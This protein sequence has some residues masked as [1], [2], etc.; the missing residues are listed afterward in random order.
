VSS[1]LPRP[2]ILEQ[3]RNGGG[4]MP[5]FRHLPPEQLAAVVD[6]VMEG[7]DEPGPPQ[8]DTSGSNAQP[9]SSAAGMVDTAFGDAYLFGGYTKFLDPDRYPAV[10]PPWGT[11]S[12]IDVSTGRYVWRKPFGEYPE[13]AAQGMKDTGSPNYG[14]AVVTAGGVLFIG[15]TVFDNKFHAFA[16]RTGKLLWEAQLPA[17][18]LAS[19]AT[20]MAGG[21]QYVVVCAGGGKNIRQPNG[22]S[23]VAFALPAQGLD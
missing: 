20:Y 5:P 14:G 17:A 13:L 4:R 15:A 1:R 22:G 16:K 10:Q 7:R 9:S 6:Y 19:P 3:V 23:V 12:A 11:L 2:D 21:K 8:A 18:A